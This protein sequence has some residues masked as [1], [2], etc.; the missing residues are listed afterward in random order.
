VLV[1][2]AT[3]EVPV[4]RSWLGVSTRG[5]Q[6]GHLNRACDVVHVQKHYVSFC[7]WR[8]PE[9]FGRLD[10]RDIAIVKAG[11]RTWRV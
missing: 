2:E 5:R 1:Q 9:D 6:I 10:P 3:L 7:A 8:C 11:G 4:Q